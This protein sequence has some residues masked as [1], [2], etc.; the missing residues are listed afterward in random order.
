[1]KGRAILG[2]VATAILCV[3]LSQISIKLRKDSQNEFQETLEKFI[4]SSITQDDS[5]AHK[6]MTDDVQRLKE[7]NVQGIY[8][9]KGE[10][11][12][13]NAKLPTLVSEGT[14]FTEVE[15][16]EQTKVQTFLYSFTQEVDESQI[17]KEIISQLKANMVAVLRN[18]RNNIRRLNAGMTFLYVYYSVDNKRLYDIKIESK[19][20]NK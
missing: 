7:G 19:D 13:V 9:T 4:N 5:I 8:P 2:M 16:N 3:V 17:T 12:S 18:D 10:I 14:L 11:D 15:Y 6:Q 1:M 20:I